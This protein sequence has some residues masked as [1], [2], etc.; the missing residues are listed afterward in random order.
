MPWF[1]QLAATVVVLFSTVL[2]VDYFR[3]RG[4]PRLS[5]PTFRGSGI[6]DKLSLRLAKTVTDGDFDGSQF[7]KGAFRTLFPTQIACPHC[8]GKSGSNWEITKAE[9]LLDDLGGLAR[10][11]QRKRYCRGC[12]GQ[13]SEIAKMRRKLKK[14]GDKDPQSLA[15]L[16]LKRGCILILIWILPAFITLTVIIPLALVFVAHLLVNLP[17]LIF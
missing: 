10:Q 3:R 9:G 13:L 12:L 1:V 7:G 11:I 2:V 15:G 8:K 16:S 5:L 6:P 14:L 4:L 17:T